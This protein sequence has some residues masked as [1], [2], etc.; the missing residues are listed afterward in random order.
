MTE[1]RRKTVSYLI[2]SVLRIGEFPVLPG[3]IASLVALLVHVFYFHRLGVWGL[4]WVAAVGASGLIASHRL[5]QGSPS[6]DPSWIVVDE[7]LGMMI[8]LIFIPLRWPFLLLG[9]CLFRFFDI[10]KLFPI[11]RLERLP[12]AWGVVFDDVGAGLYTNL[13]LQ[14]FVRLTS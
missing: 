2:A 13:I 5:L 4:G 3:T 1:F 14:I 12:G 10:T 6:Q 8:S 7:F 11:N 9:F